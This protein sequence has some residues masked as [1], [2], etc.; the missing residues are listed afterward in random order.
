MGVR[1]TA[2]TETLIGT[3]DAAYEF[4]GSSKSTLYFL[5]DADAPRY[6]IVAIDVDHPDKANW[7]ELVAQARDTLQSA[8]IVNRS[9]V[10]TYM[11]DAHSAV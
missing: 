9:L 4:L 11:Q 7:K 10:A 5:T 3:W 8:R 1:S 2:P 6:R